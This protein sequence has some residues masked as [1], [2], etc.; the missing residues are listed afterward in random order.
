MEV[1]FNDPKTS[2]FLKHYKYTHWVNIL[3]SFIHHSINLVQKN[4][5]KKHPE[6]EELF[7][8]L[9]E[10]VNKN[11]MKEMTNLY[12]SIHKI[13]RKL[14]KVIKS[15]E[16][17]IQRYNIKLKKG[18]VLA[19]FDNILHEGVINAFLSKKQNESDKTKENSDFDTHT[20]QIDSVNKENE[21]KSI[22]K[23]ATTHIGF[24]IDCIKDPDEL[25][26]IN[27]KHDTDIAKSF[28]Y[29][30]KFEFNHDENKT[31]K[32]KNPLIRSNYIESSNEKYESWLTNNVQKRKHRDSENKCSRI[33]E[34]SSKKFDKIRKASVKHSHTKHYTQIG[35][36]L[37]YKY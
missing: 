1:L 19:D 10:A 6:I 2:E 24:N 31:P 37:R 14:K 3:K 34:K 22:D 12:G 5:P 16:S 21:N 11:L 7:K 15:N 18:N 30:R 8:F 35:D 25:S 29:D 27:I 28:I 23:T 32:N 33:E 36:N 13:D 17:K 20:S 26:L 4:Y 9:G